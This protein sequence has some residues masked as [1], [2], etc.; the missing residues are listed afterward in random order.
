MSFQFN[1]GRYSLLPAT[2]VWGFDCGQSEAIRPTAHPDDDAFVRKGR[3]IQQ[4][5]ADAGWNIEGID[6]VVETAQ[7]MDGRCFRFL[8]EI[9][10]ETDGKPFELIFRVSPSTAAQGQ[11]S[12]ELV[13]FR[14]GK[15]RWSD[16]LP[17]SPSTEMAF[18]SLTTSLLA[19][20][21][22]LPQAVGRDAINS[23][24]DANLAR[25]CADPPIPVPDIFPKLYCWLTQDQWG[26]NKIVVPGHSR[27]LL[28]FGIGTSEDRA[29]LHPRAHSSFNYATVNPNLRGSNGLQAPDQ[30]ALPVEINLKALNEIYVIDAARKDDLERCYSEVLEKSGRSTPTDD[31]FSDYMTACARSMVAITEY[32]GGYEKPVY[33]IGRQLDRTEAH[34]IIGDIHVFYDGSVLRSSLIEAKNGRKVLIHESDK[35][36]LSNMEE[37]I[38][39][40]EF[41]TKMMGTSL[42]LSQQLIREVKSLRDARYVEHL[43]SSLASGERSEIMTILLKP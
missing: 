33:L 3:E 37:F 39:T 9:T 2:F 13:S 24:G 8:S 16:D 32:R 21:A 19:K 25:L 40:G 38:R 11:S 14:F 28:P 22:S 18:Q 26:N 34:F 1:N 30:L 12:N 36:T 20:L 17:V 7:T 10:G 43:K 5:L 35:I 6:A 23:L 31:E 42:H 27:P 15:T 29:R 41:L 4:A